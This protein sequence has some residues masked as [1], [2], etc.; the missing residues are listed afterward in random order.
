[1]LGC[2]FKKL[3]LLYSVLISRVCTCMG[4]RLRN[5]GDTFRWMNICST[6]GVDGHRLGNFCAETRYLGTSCTWSVAIA[7]CVWF[8]WLP[9]PST[10][11]CAEIRKLVAR[12]C[13]GKQIDPQNL[14]SLPTGALM[15]SFLVVHLSEKKKGEMTY[16]MPRRPPAA[17]LLEDKYSVHCCI[18]PD[19]DFKFS[20]QPTLWLCFTED[21][22]K[23]ALP[24]SHFLNRECFHTKEW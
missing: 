8:Q 10:S 20:I 4:V 2:R 22:R 5:F 16:N 12:Q 18:R 1:M 9:P 3:H 23:G 24:V 17:A 11:H 6:A 19:H 7:M 21:S 14:M 13:R 15:S